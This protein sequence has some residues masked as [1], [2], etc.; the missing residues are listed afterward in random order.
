MKSIFKYKD[1]REYLRDYYNENKK[2]SYGF[3]VRFFAKK[4]GLN[5]GNYLKLVMDGKRNLTHKNVKN[6]ARGLDLNDREG[7]YF[8]N[9]VFMT[10]SKDA[11]ERKFYEKN[12]EVLKDEGYGTALTKEQ[13]E[14]CSRWFYLVIKEMLLLNDFKE[15][16]SWI[17]YK[18]NREISKKEASEAID[19]LLK[20]GLIEREP[21]SRKLVPTSTSV[22]SKSVVASE[23]LKIFYREMIKK[24]L[25]CVDKQNKDERFLN[26]LTIAVNTK[27]LP[28]IFEK[29]TNFR[30]ELDEYI[31]RAKEY[32]S[33]YQLNVQFFRLLNK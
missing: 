15:D 1:Y 26:S 20:L 21:K 17:S 16:P 14:V 2:S 30:N 8:E 25:E 10:Q 9:L 28:K 3:S 27:D 7:L 6:F 33:V 23:A 11:E 12:L 18:L 32:D 24:G 13:Y 19:L 5:S 29:I 4:A 22:V 31:M